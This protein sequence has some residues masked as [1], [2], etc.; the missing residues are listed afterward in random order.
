[1][2]NNQIKCMGCGR[3]PGQI[4]EYV[5]ATKSDNFINT[6]DEYVLSE[7]GTLNR[8]TG[9]FACTDCYTKMGMPIGVAIQE[10]IYLM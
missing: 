3:K 10:W 4:E 7:E 2:I 8:N 9:K 6:P 1:M 5:D